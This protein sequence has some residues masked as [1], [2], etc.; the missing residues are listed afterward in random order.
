[1]AG[2]LSMRKSILL[3]NKPLLADKAPQRERARVSKVSRIVCGLDDAGSKVHSTLVR[4]VKD[5]H[6]K[7]LGGAV[8]HLLRKNLRH[9]RAC[10]P[11]N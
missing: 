9:V 5:C 3:A 11:V 6:I 7:F 4:R 8:K 2:F 10:R 1:M